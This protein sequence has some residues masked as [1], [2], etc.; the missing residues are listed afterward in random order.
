MQCNTG[1]WTGTDSIVTHNSFKACYTCALV[2]SMTNV[3]KNRVDSCYY[4]A[5][6]PGSLCIITDNNIDWAWP[7]GIYVYAGGNDNV[8]TGN[9]GRMAICAFT[10]SESLEDRY[11]YR[12]LGTGNRIQAIMHISNITD[13]NVPDSEFSGKCIYTTKPGN[14]L[15]IVFGGHPIDTKSALDTIIYTSATLS[16]V[17]RYN[18]IDYL[19]HGYSSSDVDMSNVIANSFGN[20]EVSSGTVLIPTICNRIV[21][22][23]VTEISGTSGVYT[24]DSDNSNVSNHVFGI[25]EPCNV[26]I[27]NIGSADISGGALQ[28]RDFDSLTSVVTQTQDKNDVV[29][30][31]GEIIKTTYDQPMYTYPALRMTAG[32]YTLK[33]VF[34]TGTLS[35]TELGKMLA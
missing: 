5:K 16:D 29:V 32:N 20:T 31:V 24:L 13:G 18:N 2:A 7:N 1:I 28:I 30:A 35:D 17:F 11:A 9:T 33:V 19:M 10:E 12:V 26:A 27:K 8:I 21:N 14:I 23:N 22:G 3:S 15:D 34:Y 4:F 6:I 25:T